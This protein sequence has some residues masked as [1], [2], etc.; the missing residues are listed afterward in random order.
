[1]K[2]SP[3]I[4]LLALP[5]ATT[6]NADKLN[7]RFV[8]TKVDYIAGD[9]SRFMHGEIPEKVGFLI[10]IPEGRATTDIGKKLIAEKNTG[11]SYVMYPKGQE[12]TWLVQLLEDPK[13]IDGSLVNSHH[14]INRF[15]SGILLQ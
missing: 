13:G 8:L 3:L 12:N 11:A 14:Q 15:G 6:V 5:Y 10:D 9:Y 2:L 7:C 1:M 4:L